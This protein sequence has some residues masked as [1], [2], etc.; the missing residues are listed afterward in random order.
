MNRR[1]NSS[2]G[3]NPP[4][5]GLNRQDIGIFNHYVVVVLNGI[6]PL[7]ITSGAIH[8]KAFQASISDNTRFLKKAMIDSL[9]YYSRSSFLFSSGVA[10][11][12]DM[13]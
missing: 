4:A 9:R 6:F 13:K 12:F 3:R 11:V 8:I 1:E 2:I 10:I 5:G 7:W